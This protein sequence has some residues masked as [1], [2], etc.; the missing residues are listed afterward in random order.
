MYRGIGFGLVL[1]DARKHHGKADVWT[2]NIG[3]ARRARIVAKAQQMLAQK[4]RYSYWD[5]AVQ[6]TWLILG[7]RIP[8]HQR[9]S[10]IC[11]VFGYDVWKS[12]GLQIARR[13]NCSPEEVA[14][15]GVLFFKGHY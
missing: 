3:S 14:L 6:F 12:A 7:L 8:W 2:Q 10:L 15:D 13:R 11:S 4:Y 1:T 9:K 5:I